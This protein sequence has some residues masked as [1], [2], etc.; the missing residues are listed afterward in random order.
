MSE[1]EYRLLSWYCYLAQAVCILV[2][3]P[4][5][6]FLFAASVARLLKI[7]GLL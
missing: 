5:A 7:Y 4:A 3:L 6:L 1:L 2:L